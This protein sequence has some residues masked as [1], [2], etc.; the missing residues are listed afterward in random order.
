M[1]GSVWR[2]RGVSAQESGQ[3]FTPSDLQWK[4][5]RVPGLDS[6]QIIGDQFKPGPYVAMLRFPIKFITQPHSHS[7]ARQCTIISGTLYIGWGDQFDATKLKALPP[8]SFYTEPANVPHFLGTKD[9]P[10]IVQ[11]T[12]TGPIATNF[13]VP[14]GA[15]K[16]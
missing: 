14:P 11:V 8:G 3:I 10:V 4:P 6:A 5:G 15:T 7:E 2:V 1:C 16:Q 12:G 13:V 9:E